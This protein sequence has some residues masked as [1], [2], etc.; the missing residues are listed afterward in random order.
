MPKKVICEYAVVE[1]EDGSFDFDGLDKKMLRW[2]ET[3]PVPWYRVP[4]YVG[5]CLHALGKKARIHVR[6]LKTGGC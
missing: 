5:V 1:Y 6:K 4:V 3:H 2:I